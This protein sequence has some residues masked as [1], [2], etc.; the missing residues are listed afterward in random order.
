VDTPA[1]NYEGDQLQPLMVDSDLPSA[2][3]RLRNSAKFGDSGPN[4]HQCRGFD[5]NSGPKLF[6]QVIK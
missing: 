6:I 4:Q 5:K 2:S 1:E 3:T